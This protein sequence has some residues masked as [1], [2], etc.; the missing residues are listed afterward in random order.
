MSDRAKTIILIVCILVI[1]FLL[2]TD[3]MKKKKQG[4]LFPLI[5]YSTYHNCHMSLGVIPNDIYLL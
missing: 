1:M 4:V 5:G 3:L 2:I